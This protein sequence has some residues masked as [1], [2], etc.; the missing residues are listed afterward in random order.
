MLAYA[1]EAVDLMR[2]R[3]RAD[4]DTDRALGLAILRCVEIVGEA[5]SQ[6]PVALRRRN[7]KIPWRQIIGMRNRLSHCY[8]IVDYDIVWST[9]TQDLPLLVAELE[10]ILP[11]EK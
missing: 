11:S 10:A 4:L 9:V 7:P 6:I 3:T 2:N 8:D 1:K 5:A